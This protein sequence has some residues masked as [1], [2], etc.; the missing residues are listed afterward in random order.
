M[1][2]ETE[3]LALRHKVVGRL[4]ILNCFRKNM[5]RIIRVCLD[6]EV[7]HVFDVASQAIESDSVLRLF[8]KV[9]T[10]IL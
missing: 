2:V 6:Q 7:M 1:T 5:V 10:V 8:C 3:N 9:S 4:F